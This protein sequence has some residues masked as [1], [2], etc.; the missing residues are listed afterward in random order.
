MA[1]APTRV[2]GPR[3]AR[4]SQI[5]I[6]PTLP[7]PSTATK[8]PTAPPFGKSILYPDAVA[9]PALQAVGPAALQQMQAAAAAQAAAQASASAGA[10]DGGV[11]ASSPAP[12]SGGGYIAPDSAPI[13]SAPPSSEAPPSSQ[14]DSQGNP[15]PPPSSPMVVAPPMP[16]M[17]SPRERIGAFLRTREGKLLALLILG[18]LGYAAFLFFQRK[19]RTNPRRRKK[20]RKGSERHYHRKGEGHI[21]RWR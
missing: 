3:A 14:V 7:A 2:T 18:G 9:N 1:R 6:V 5:S 12:S 19:K 21:E 17:L 10:A 16:M 13:S 8:L 4:S 20:A 11:P 15:L